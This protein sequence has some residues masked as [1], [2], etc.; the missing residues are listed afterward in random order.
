[1]TLRFKYI[2]MGASPVNDQA[3]AGVSGA[4]IKAGGVLAVGANFY[5]W[6]IYEDRK[7]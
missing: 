1:M 5:L 3:I 2:N 4:D 6:Y 7:S